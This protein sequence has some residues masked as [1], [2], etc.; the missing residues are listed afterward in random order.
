MFILGPYYHQIGCNTSR[1]TLQGVSHT[2]EQKNKIN[3]F[4][5][6]LVPCIPCIG[7]RHILREDKLI[8]GL[9]YELRECALEIEE[10]F[11]I[12]VLTRFVSVT[13]SVSHHPVRFYPH[14]HEMF[15]NDSHSLT[16]FTFTNFV[17]ELLHGIWKKKPY[18]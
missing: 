1:V 12:T 17:K 4:R 10:Q 9:L 7:N 15:S 14:F 6:I 13:E 18:L 8:L 11:K 3:N 5:I 16:V 2:S